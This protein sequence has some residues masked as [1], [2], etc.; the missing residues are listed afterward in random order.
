MWQDLTVGMWMILPNKRKDLWKERE[1]ESI[2]SL[3]QKKDLLES[4]IADLKKDSDDFVYK[5]EHET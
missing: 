2:L 4:T 1:T 3:N 5:A